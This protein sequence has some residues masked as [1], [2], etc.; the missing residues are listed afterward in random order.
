MRLSELAKILKKDL[1]MLRYLCTDG[2]F[3]TAKK[4]FVDH[5]EKWFVDDDEALDYIKNYKNDI[6]KK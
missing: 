6:N 3:K 1:R 2:T 4:I 5:G